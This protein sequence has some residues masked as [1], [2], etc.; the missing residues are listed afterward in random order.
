MLTK[1]AATLGLLSLAAFSF[2]EAVNGARRLTSVGCNPSSCGNLTN[3]RSPFRLKADPPQ[4]GSPSYELICQNNRTFLSNNLGFYVAD[5]FYDGSGT[6]RLVDQSLDAKQCSILPKSPVCREVTDFI[7]FVS[8]RAPMASSL[9]VDAAPCANASSPYPY[10]YALFSADSLNATGFDESCTVEIQV[11]R[12]VRLQS[13]NISALRRL[14]IFDIHRELLMGY[15]VPWACAYTPRSSNNIT[16]AKILWRL[17]FILYN[18]FNS[19]RIFFAHAFPS[20]DTYIYYYTS[21]TQVIFLILTGVAIAIRTLIGVSS[22]IIVVV[23]KF[24]RR[25]LCV[26]DTIEE[27]LRMQNKLMPIRYSYSDIKRM[28]ESFKDKLGQGGFGSVFKGKLRSG[29]LVAIKLLELS[30]SQGQDFINEVATI[31]R[32]HHVNVVRLV[33]FCVEGSKQALVYDFMPNSSLDKV[34]FSKEKDISLSWEKLSEIAIG[35]AQGIEYLHQGCD[36][37][38]LHFDIKPHNILLDENF[39]PKVSDFGLAKLH[40]IDNSIVSLTAARGRRRNLNAQARQ[41]SEIYFPSWIY[42]RFDRG[43]DLE[44]EDATES[45]KKTVRKMI[46][47]AFWCIQI[48][49]TD[50]PS[51]SEV[52]EMLG[53]DVELLEIPPKPFLLSMERSSEDFEDELT[54]SADDATTT[55]SMEGA[56]YNIHSSN[57]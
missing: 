18:Y 40:A 6:I 47:V 33:G 42:D 24:R 43:E 54:T 15:D 21:R 9:Y 12:P 37:Q 45:Q 4:C 28:T 16:L 7:Y 44:V 22:L 13:S 1:V 5:I 41:S 10:F 27:F 56:E 14:S 32:I 53:G 38:I 20:Q 19:F 3:I 23:F 35:V 8:C 2:F 52:L 39:T 30:K 50:R 11:P 49:P 57:D 48:K 51:M 46:I 26:D 34:I 55:M 36:M 29:H 31:G 17:K 25:H